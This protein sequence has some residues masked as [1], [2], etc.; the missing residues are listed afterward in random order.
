[1]A[2]NQIQKLEV[3]NIKMRVYFFFLTKEK[4]PFYF[5]R[6]RQDKTD[7]Q[8]WCFLHYNDQNSVVKNI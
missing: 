5:S 1:M 3:S 7:T 6:S 2:H 8:N 4:T